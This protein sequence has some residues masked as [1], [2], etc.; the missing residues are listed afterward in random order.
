MA[1]GGRCY[2]MYTV[3]DVKLWRHIHVFKPTLWRSLLTQHVY[4]STHTLLTR[5]CTMFHC[6]QHKLTALQ[7]VRLEQNI[8]LNTKTEVHNCKNIRQR[9]KTA[10]TNTLSAMSAQFTT[11]KIQYKAAHYNSWVKPTQLH[12]RAVHHCKNI[13]PRECL[14]E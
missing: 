11:A 6:N 5:C 3:R 9:V 8:A 10:E 4:Y 1:Y 14:V 7:V 2:W 13:R 12:D